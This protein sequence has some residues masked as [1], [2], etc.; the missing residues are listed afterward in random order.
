MSFDPISLLTIG[1]FIGVAATGASAIGNLQASQY[2]AAVAERNAV[3]MDQNAKRLAEKAQQDVQDLGE[4]QAAEKGQM[5][6]EMGASG[7]DIASGSTALQRA[8]LD[9]LARRDAQRTA[10][11]GGNDVR[12]AQQSAADYRS[13]ALQQ[14][15]AGKMQLFGDLAGGFDSYI[16]SSTAIAKAK[17]DLLK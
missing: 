1:K 11:E 8:A 16:S 12:Q 5:L 17:L 14:K 3:L 6:A 10:V 13:S 15:K 4:Q 9:R 2:N 7:F